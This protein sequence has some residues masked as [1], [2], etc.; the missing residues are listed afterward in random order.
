MYCCKGIKFDA[1]GN[2]YVS[3]TTSR[4]GSK[5]TPGSLAK[6]VKKE[7]NGNYSLFQV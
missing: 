1:K 6:L 5:E 4:W 7:E 3:S 2:A